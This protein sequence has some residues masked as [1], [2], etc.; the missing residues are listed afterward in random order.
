MLQNQGMRTSTAVNASDKRQGQSDFL[1]Q[2]GEAASNPETP[3]LAR[4][5]L[6]RLTVSAGVLQGKRQGG[7][8]CDG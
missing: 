8:Y 2:A 7:K 1:S 4:Q 5:V 6:P 3:L